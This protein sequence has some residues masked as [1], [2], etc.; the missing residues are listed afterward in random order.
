MRLPDLEMIQHLKN[1]P[2]QHFDGVGRRSPLVVL[3]PPVAA[4]INQQQVEMPLEVED[5]FEPDAGA[6]ARAM[7]ENDP[8]LVGATIKRLEIEHGCAG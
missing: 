7:D 8:V 5:L 6:A 3:R 4:Q 1:I 2:A